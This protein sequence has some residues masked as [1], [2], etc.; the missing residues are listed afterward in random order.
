MEKLLIDF[1]KG[2]PLLI[3]A[4]ADIIRRDTPSILV[5]ETDSPE[6]TICKPKLLSM[7]QS[8]ILGLR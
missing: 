4:I 1:G 7:A 6:A 2:A 8:A 3:A 5:V